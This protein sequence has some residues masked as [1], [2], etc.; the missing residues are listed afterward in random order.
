MKEIIVQLISAAFASLGYSILFNA[1]P[2]RLPYLTLGGLITWSAYLISA[3]FLGGVFIPNLIATVI[4]GIYS[5]VLARIIKVPVVVII[6]PSIIPLVPGA[7][8]YYTLYNFINKDYGLCIEK[9]FSTFMICLGIAAG[10]VI[11]SIIGSSIKKR[12]FISIFK[13]T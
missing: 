4:A 3:H 13:Q 7:G 2:K 5:E 6:T 8:L 1:I 12:P 9:L 11:S 10:M